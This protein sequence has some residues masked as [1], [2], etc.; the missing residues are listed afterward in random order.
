MPAT[1]WRPLLLLA[2]LVFIDQGIK[3]V[4]H[5]KYCRANR[6]IWPG[7]LQFRPVQ[8]TRHSWLGGQGRAFVREQGLCRFD[9]T[10]GELYFCGRHVGG[11]GLQRSRHRVYGVCLGRG[12]L[13]AD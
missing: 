2:L 1:V 4:I 5:R 10:G 11:H 13:F 9:Q 8:N 3:L 6:V 12:A 7:R